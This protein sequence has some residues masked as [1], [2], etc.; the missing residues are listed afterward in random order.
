MP[1]TTIHVLRIAHPLFRA[2]VGSTSSG[3]TEKR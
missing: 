2:V 3:Q 1:A